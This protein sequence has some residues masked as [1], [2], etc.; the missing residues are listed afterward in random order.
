[1]EKATAEKAGPPRPEV[2]ALVRLIDDEILRSRISKRKLEKILGQ[3]QGYVASLTRGRIALKVG[4]VYDL[5]EALGLEPL[6]LFYRAAPKKNQE[7]FLQELRLQPAAE[8]AAARKTPALTLAEI[9]EMVRKIVRQEL[10]R[11]AGL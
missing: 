1:M 3:G 9:E 7:R 6:L 5:A 11:L 8:D 2:E 4:H 10:G